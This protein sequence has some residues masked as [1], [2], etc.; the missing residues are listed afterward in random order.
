[1]N[2]RIEA[3][4]GTWTKKTVITHLGGDAYLTVKITQANLKEPIVVEFAELGRRSLSGDTKIPVP[5][6]N[7]EVIDRRGD[8]RRKDYSPLHH[9]ASLYDRKEFSE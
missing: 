9:Y 2:Y 5:P 6:R 3:P 1:M 4:E 7:V 8:I